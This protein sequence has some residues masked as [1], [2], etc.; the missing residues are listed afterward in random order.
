MNIADHLRLRQQ[1]QV[2][3]VLQVL[4]RVLE[5]L[6]ADVRLGH[7][8]G[9]DRRAH[10][11]IDNRD[12]ALEN[13]HQGMF[14]GLSYLFDDCKRLTDQNVGSKQGTGT[15]GDWIGRLKA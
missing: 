13:L 9:A 4:L 11:A 1:K 14:G 5:S 3:V 8:I 15:I 12:A 6:P 10:R 7:A 2:A